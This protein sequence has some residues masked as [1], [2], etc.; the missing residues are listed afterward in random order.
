MGIKL[1][2]TFVAAGLPA[3]SMRLSAVMSGGVNGVD[4]LELVTDLV[5]TLL[6]AI[7]RLGVATAAEIGV[8]TLADRMSREVISRNS[9]IVG[10]AEIAAWTRV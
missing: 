1:H 9:V 5:E 7:E 3:P 2:S 6:P 4:H 8:E 10:C